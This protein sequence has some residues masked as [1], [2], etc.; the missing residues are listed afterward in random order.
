[1]IGLAI[2]MGAASLLIPGQSDTAIA[3]ESQPANDPTGKALAHNLEVA[4]GSPI[5]TNRASQATGSIQSYVQPE[6]NSTPLAKPDQ[7]KSMVV[8]SNHQSS[9]SGSSEKQQLKNLWENSKVDE[10]KP[11]LSTER[12]FVPTNIN[13]SVVTPNA[14]PI[15]AKQPQAG[16]TGINNVNEQ[17]KAKQDVALDR[18]KQSSNRLKN[19][20]AE[21]R[22]EES[23]SSKFSPTKLEEKPSL[24]TQPSLVVRTAVP[25]GSQNTEEKRILEVPQPIVVESTT[26]AVSQS[27]NKTVKAESSLSEI[28]VPKVIEPAP[29]KRTAVV[30]PSLVKYQVSSGDTLD[31]IAKNYGV[32]SQELAKA[33]SISDPNWLQV[34][35]PLEI[36]Q[37]RSAELAESGL[38]VPSRT[39]LNAVVG[40]PTQIL[41]SNPQSKQ[42]ASVKVTNGLVV[43][44]LTTPS[45]TQTLAFI[46]PL[47]KTSTNT[48]VTVPTVANSLETSD[49]EAPVTETQIK[50]LHIS[51]QQL[52]QPSSVNAETRY[53]PYVEN[54]RGEI[55]KLREKYRAQRSS[56]RDNADANNISAVPAPAKAALN[57]THIPSRQINP[58]F[59][60]ELHNQALHLENQTRPNNP[61]TRLPQVRVATGVQP[62]PYQ[63]PTA[64]PIK[65]QAPIV[66]TAPLGS[67]AYDPSQSSLGRNVSPG[68]PPLAPADTYLPKN[69][70]NFTG[71][72][73]PAKGVLTSGFGW[74]WGRLH[75]GID[76]AGP[77]GTPVVASAPGVITYA[78]WN[79]GGYG[80]LVE[81]T[82][83]D[84]STTLYGHNNRI[85]VEEGQ[86]VEQGQQ[87]AEMGSTGFSTGPH[88]HFEIHPPGQDAVNPI[89]FLPR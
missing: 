45:K 62:L 51:E 37:N 38:T 25:L 70:A 76:V 60:P 69:S 63:A 74:R 86:K 71:Y 12:Q 41:P 15:A 22:S 7:L 34:N 24:R 10:V 67:D 59:N 72:I 57:N 73:W 43:S 50:S 2:S 88:S 68:L 3:A 8:N 5:A 30:V 33:N 77:V 39:S 56:D 42:I 28:T 6:T 21:L 46:P 1:M 54:L 78:R 80:N 84:G 17:L 58:E 4:T 55:L 85:V 31:A 11:E 18:L 32:S 53:N 48:G 49:T 9:E 16:E 19:S 66:A 29:G 44:T 82:H 81:V 26:T 75:K 65:S 27:E 83:P 89:A 64:V 87:I 13:S 36:P 61:Q 20:L 47:T 23:L 79:D 35:Q 14:E 40:I 52:N